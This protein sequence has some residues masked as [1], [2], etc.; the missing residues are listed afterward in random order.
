MYARPAARYVRRVRSRSVSQDELGKAS[1][2]S[3]P[4]PKGRSRK[5]PISDSTELGIK[6]SELR[7]ALLGTWCPFSTPIER[8]RRQITDDERNEQSCSR[9]IGLQRMLGCAQLVHNVE[10]PRAEVGLRETV[11]ALT[12]AVEY[13]LPEAAEHTRG[14]VEDHRDTPR[15]DR[16]VRM[17]GDE[18]AYL[19]LRGQDQVEGAV[20]RDQLLTEGLVHKYEYVVV[21]IVARIAA[22]PRSVQRGTAVLGP[23]PKALQER[24]EPRVS[25]VSR[26]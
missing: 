26:A 9:R 12:L 20:L 14:I 7:Q 5:D 23:L 25:H 1:G 16:V 15:L 8:E 22:R 10:L 11:L 4:C 21:T 6:L 3:H 2:G 19:L 24:I 13:V 17:T 18:C